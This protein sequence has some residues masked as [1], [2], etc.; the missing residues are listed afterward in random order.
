LKFH[1]KTEQTYKRQ[2]GYDGAGNP[3]ISVKSFIYSKE[4]HNLWQSTDG[5]WGCQVLLL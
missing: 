1:K 3:A 4:T 2:P 5:G